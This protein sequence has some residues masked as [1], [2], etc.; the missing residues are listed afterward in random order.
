MSFFIPAE[1]NIAPLET[2]KLV[3]AETVVVAPSQLTTETTVV[4]ASSSTVTTTEYFELRR[5]NDDGTLEIERLN[6]FQGDGLLDKERFEKFISD[7][8][9]GEYEIWF[10]MR[11]NSSGTVIERPVIHF[12]LEGG[13]LAPPPNDSPTLFKPFRLVPV[14]MNPPPA[15]DAREAVENSDA[16]TD[17]DQQPMA[18]NPGDKSSDAKQS[19]EP[20]LDSSSVSATDSAIDAD[21]LKTEFTNLNLVIHSSDSHD[22]SSPTAVSLAV[23]VLVFSGTRRWTRQTTESSTSLFSRSSRLARKFAE[24]G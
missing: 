20:S 19:N 24:Q 1:P 21:D 7:K 9:D 3:F 18:D 8:G 22:Q 15:N 23:G 6:D 10:I 12:R 17:D 11:E 2:P 14:P 16:A 4:S 13:L 5:F